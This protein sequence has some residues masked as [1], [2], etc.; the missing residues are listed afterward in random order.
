MQTL[1]R[2]FDPDHDPP[3]FC[4]RWTLLCRPSRFSRARV[5]LIL[6]RPP[7]HL[8]RAHALTPK[9]FPPS[10][11]VRV[12]K[13]VRRPDKLQPDGGIGECLDDAGDVGRALWREE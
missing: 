12:G 7:Q 2:A 6:R 10:V 8:E 13:R 4:V 11:R 5:Q 3:A 1:E 9:M